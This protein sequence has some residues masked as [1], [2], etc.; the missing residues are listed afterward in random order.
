MRIKQ[1]LYG[2]KKIDLKVKVFIVDEINHEDLE[3]K[4]FDIQSDFTLL[5][6]KGSYKE[7]NNLFSKVLK[8][9][10]REYNISRIESEIHQH[11]LT[12]IGDFI[13]KT[14]HGNDYLKLVLKI[15]N[16]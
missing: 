10:E 15:S 7:L 6:L 8:K 14:S 2:D 3:I 11:D 16:S 5:E 9:L 4:T 12:M 1:Y 13:Q